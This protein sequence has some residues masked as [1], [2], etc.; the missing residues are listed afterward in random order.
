MSKLE[1]LSC[2]L[3]VLGSF[4]NDLNKLLSGSCGLCWDLVYGL[5]QNVPSNETLDTHRACVSTE[6]WEV[7]HQAGSDTAYALRDAIF[8]KSARGMPISDI[9][10]FP[11]QKTHLF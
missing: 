11:F 9:F 1:L 6:P 2:S 5:I 8:V 4:F 3:P 7:T 10:Q